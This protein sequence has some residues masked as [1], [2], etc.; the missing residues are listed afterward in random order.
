MEMWIDKYKAYLDTKCAKCGKDLEA[1][2][3][4]IPV[5]SNNETIIV[6]PCE[7]STPDA[8]AAAE[9]VMEANADSDECLACGASCVD[10]E[11]G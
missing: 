10:R 7:C 6:T 2:M 11:E 9:I 5:G 1:E 4:A 3:T 8:D